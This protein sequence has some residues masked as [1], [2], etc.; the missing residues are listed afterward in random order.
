M[1]RQE[2]DLGRHLALEL[3][4]DGHG[5]TPQTEAARTT[6]SSV[7]KLVSGPL[8]IPRL[9]NPACHATLWLLKSPCNPPS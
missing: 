3:A 8:H 9:A 7:H 2:A 6:D 4:Q 5:L 1:V